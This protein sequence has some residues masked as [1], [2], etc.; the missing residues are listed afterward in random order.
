MSE[1]PS[2]DDTFYDRLGKLTRSRDEHMV[3]AIVKDQLDMV[4]A[5]RDTAT[6]RIA[7]L[8]A[9][10]AAAEKVVEAAEWSYGGLVDALAEF[11]KA[12][13]PDEDSA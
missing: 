6:R 4:D 2:A 5:Q 12:T 7:T 11:R 9:E 10:L 8:T 13:A 1:H 3:K